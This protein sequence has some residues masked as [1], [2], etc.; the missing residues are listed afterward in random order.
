MVR[1]RREMEGLEVD[2]ERTPPPWMADEV[3]RTHLD[4]DV[5]ASIA[6]LPHDGPGQ[7]LAVG[8]P[9]E[10]L[11][12]LAEGSGRIL[13]VES[14]PERAQRIVGE[15]A[16]RR[17]GTRLTVQRRSYAS[18][19]FERSAFRLAIL[20]DEVN[21]Y[22]NP[23]NV[24]RKCARELTVGGTMVLRMVVR[25]RLR[26]DL[27]G[28]DAL[29]RVPAWLQRRV[30]RARE[31]PEAAVL[32]RRWAVDLETLLEG[33]RDLVQVERIDHPHVV[34]PALAAVAAA[35]PAPAR[36][37][38]RRALAAVASLDRRLLAWAGADVATTAV[39]VGSKSLG[40]GR[41]FTLREQPSA[42]R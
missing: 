39:L 8:V 6:A 4:A 11:W 5:L 13:V 2:A 15:A 9:T 41:V 18:I 28:L 32:G 34:A 24:V 30:A 29:R 17:L 16:E 3:V 31:L 10:L 40:F 42:P 36:R 37:A 35:A 14:D 23:V 20:Y 25:P 19:S 1:L 22:G 7:V 38:A 27:R 33:V 21:R 26:L 12:R